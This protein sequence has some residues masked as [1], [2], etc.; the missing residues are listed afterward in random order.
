M[1]KFALV[2][3]MVLGLALAGCGS[4]SHA[5][6]NINGN[7]QAT[8]NSSGT[9]TIAFNTLLTVN[10]G[11]SLGTSNFT[12]TVNN[13]ACSFQSTTESG[14]F[15]LQGNF[16]GQVSGTF[17]YTVETTG[18]EKNT[19]TLNG[20]VSGGQI[21]GTWTLSGATANCSGN[22]TFIMTPA[23]TPGM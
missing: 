7:W 1:N 23:A 9:E 13:T 2:V 15:M 19:L 14:S 12:V 20:M 17:Q 5:T 11:G 4:N 10:A 22:G 18:V 6:G 3:L 8:L 21:T 16:N